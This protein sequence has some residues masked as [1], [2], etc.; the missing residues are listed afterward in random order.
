MVREGLI[1]IVLLFDYLTDEEIISRLKERGL[2]NYEEI[3]SKCIE[4]N[5]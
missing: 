3:K 1:Q 5:I 2:A 4:R